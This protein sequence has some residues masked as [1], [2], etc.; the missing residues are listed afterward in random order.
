[1]VF[2]RAGYFGSRILCTGVGT[3]HVCANVLWFIGE[4]VT[5][6]LV[7]EF[8]LRQWLCFVWCR[9]SFAFA[10][11]CQPFCRQVFVEPE[12]G[13]FLE[14]KYAGCWGSQH[15]SWSGNQSKFG[16]KSRGSHYF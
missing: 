2:A 16:Y 14:S 13:V 12:Y 4:R 11:S 3:V 7:D 9:T 5:S 6:L 15:Q 8:Y 1:V 10:A